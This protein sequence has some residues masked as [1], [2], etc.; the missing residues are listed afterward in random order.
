M[1]QPLPGQFG[2]GHGPRAEAGGLL[3]VSRRLDD[4]QSEH[5]ATRAQAIAA[6]N[7]AN[8]NAV[9]TQAVFMSP[10]GLTFPNDSA[11]HRYGLSGPYTCPP[12]CSVLT[13]FLW[14]SSGTSFA[15]GQTGV[16]EVQIGSGQNPS[17]S[18]QSP[19]GQYVA[20]TSGTATGAA[21]TSQ[22]TWAGTQTL[23][24]PGTTLFLSVFAYAAGSSVA[25]SSGVNLNGVLFWSRH[26]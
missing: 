13:W 16:L 18:D 6:A 19:V 7:A 25:G 5:M 12:N 24:T 17:G 10:S 26:D 8:A 3:D 14:A 4:L 22:I 11:W 23:I 1:V 21:M 20:Q 15:P 9:D 2:Y